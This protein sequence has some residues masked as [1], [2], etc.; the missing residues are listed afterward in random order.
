MSDTQTFFVKLR[1]KVTGPHT[2]DEIAYMVRQGTVSP[3]HEIS[4]D[5]KRWQPLHEIDGWQHLWDGSAS[6]TKRQLDSTAEPPPLPYAVKEE[7]PGD[8]DG[9]ERI[10]VELL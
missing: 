8:N 2:R 10:D 5:Q 3:V 7:R 1:A 6:T 4:L 9:D